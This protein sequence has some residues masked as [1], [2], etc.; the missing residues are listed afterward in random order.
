M[1]LSWGQSLVGWSKFPPFKLCFFSQCADSSP[2]GNIG[3]RGSPRFQPWICREPKAPFDGKF[4][5]DPLGLTVTHGQGFPIFR[6]T[7]TPPPPPPP[8]PAPPPPP[9][10]P[11]HNHPHQ[12]HDRLPL[13]FFHWTLERRS[14]RHVGSCTYSYA[15]K[16]LQFVIEFPLQNPRTGV[17]VKEAHS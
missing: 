12:P 16:W 11:P 9:P 13:G 15:P 3:Y 14:S 10:P 8:P 1:E 4:R 5:K 6:H 7:A 2:S 17:P